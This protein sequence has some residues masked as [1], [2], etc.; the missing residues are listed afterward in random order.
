MNHT[1]TVRVGQRVTDLGDDVD[2]LARREP[3]ASLQQ[4]AGVES[5][6]VLHDDEVTRL[7]PSIQNGDDVRV[8]EMCAQPSFIA[9]AFHE[10]RV[11]CQ[12]LGD[13]L[14]RH[15]ALHQ[16]VVGAVDDG[17]PTGTDPSEQVIPILDEAT[18]SNGRRASTVAI[19]PTPHR[20]LDVAWRV[21]HHR[22]TSGPGAHG[23]PPYAQERECQRRQRN[24][25]QRHRENEDQFH[26]TKDLAR[27]IICHRRQPPSPSPA[28]RTMRVPASPHVGKTDGAHAACFRCIERVASAD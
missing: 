10:R 20:Q 3:P 5:V 16:L 8:R 27:S 11:G 21:R 6:H 23:A 12:A 4:P 25:A 15:L 24:D 19:Q 17:H 18:R 26:A 9:E 1:L 28:S 2:G 7:N 22:R 14:D 13:E